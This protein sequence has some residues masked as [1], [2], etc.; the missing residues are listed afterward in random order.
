MEKSI[1][2]IGLLTVKQAAQE[3]GVTRST[4]HLWIKR[5]WLFAYR[6]DT[7]KLVKADDIPMALKKANENRRAAGRGGMRLSDFEVE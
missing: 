5:G 2:E 4:I 3:A 7:Y 1:R 6:A